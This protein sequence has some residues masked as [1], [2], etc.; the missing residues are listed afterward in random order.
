MKLVC[1][2]AFVF[3]LVP[4][5]LALSL[6]FFFLFFFFFI[7]CRHWIIYVDVQLERPGKGVRMF[8]SKWE[9]KEVKVNFVKQRWNRCAS[10]SFFFGLIPVL[11]L[12]R[13]QSQKAYSLTK[14]VYF[15]VKKIIYGLILSL[16]T[17]DYT[18]LWCQTFSDLR[19]FDKYIIFFFSASKVES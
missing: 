1:A 17:H 3:V 7:C 5:S 4:V 16:I 14:T 8:G 11:M 2:A 9:K 6:C 10:R 12:C 19:Y 18:C 15:D 13:I